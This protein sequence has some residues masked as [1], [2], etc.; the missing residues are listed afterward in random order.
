MAKRPFVS[1]AGDY[2]L[3]H[4]FPPIISKAITAG[5]R[6]SVCHSTMIFRT[7]RE[8]ANTQHPPARCSSKGKVKKRM[9]HNNT[10]LHCSIAVHEIVLRQIISV[11]LRAEYLQKMHYI[12]HTLT[13]RENFSNFI[14]DLKQK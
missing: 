11:A 2:T 14:L 12:Y 4:F 9:K 5:V 3:T 13:A 10:V 7:D 1:G 6:R 8:I